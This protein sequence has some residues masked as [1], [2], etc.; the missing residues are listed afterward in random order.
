MHGGD[1]V[2][3]T[4]Q[5]AN[6]NT[7]RRQP[8]TVEALKEAFARYGEIVA[9]ETQWRDPQYRGKAWITFADTPPAQEAYLQMSGFSILGSNIVVTMHDTVRFRKRSREEVLGLINFRT[10]PTPTTLLLLEGASCFWVE[11][12]LRTARG[13]VSCGACLCTSAIVTFVIFDSVSAACRAKS[14]Y[15]GSSVFESSASIRLRIHY[16]ELIRSVEQ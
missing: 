3:Q 11:A 16:G 9:I 5:I 2:P 8:E 13:F 7:E 4:L 6:L 10:V 14:R 12:V 1:R 15:A